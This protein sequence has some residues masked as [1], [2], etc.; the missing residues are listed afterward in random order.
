MKDNIDKRIAE[1]D[2]MV[3][4]STGVDLAKLDKQLE[5]TRKSSMGFDFSYI[6]LDDSIFLVKSR[7]AN[8]TH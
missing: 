1:I 6:V 7:V 8:A 3:K 5:S 2:K 4:E